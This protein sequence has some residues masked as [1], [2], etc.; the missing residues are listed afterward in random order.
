MD[1]LSRSSAKPSDIV[2]VENG[3]VIEDAAVPQGT[4]LHTVYL[5]HNPGYGAAVNA[6]ME[7]VPSGVEWV[8]VMNPDVVFAGDALEILLG[9][10]SRFPEAGSLGP[11]LLNPDGSVYPSARAI[12][13][14]GIGIG[15]AL[16]GAIW[17]SNPWTKAYRGT[18]DSPEPRQ[19]G[20]LSGACLMVRREAFTSIGGF[21]TGY[22]MFMEDVDLGL[23]LSQAG[24]ENVYVPRARAIHEVGHATGRAKL[25]M[26]KAHHLSARRFIAKLYPGA[27]YAPLRWL[28]SLGLTLRQW[29]VQGL[30]LPRR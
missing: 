28:V 24:F 1:S 13:R 7:I 8:V 4:T 12:P 21:D 23:R 16:L 20:W 18:Y 17:K 6:G 22:F 9:E 30:S 26:A 19:V 11:S 27:R 10:A 15:H 29:L 2:L 3:P 14:L 25:A 5:P